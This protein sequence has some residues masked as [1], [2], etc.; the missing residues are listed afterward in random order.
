MQR[1]TTRAHLVLGDEHCRPISEL[2]LVRDGGADRLSILHRQAALTGEQG[3]GLD[4]LGNVLSGTRSTRSR[5][6]AH[7]RAAGRPPPPCYDCVD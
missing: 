1:R 7:P 5:Q 4:Q 2:A 3:Q 6:R